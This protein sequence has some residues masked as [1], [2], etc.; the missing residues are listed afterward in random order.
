MA[1]V[2][3]LVR[4][5]KCPVGGKLRISQGNVVRDKVFDC[6]VQILR[7]VLLLK[8]YQYNASLCEMAASAESFEVITDPIP[9]PSARGARWANT[10]MD[11]IS[12]PSLLPGWPP[13]E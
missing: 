13:V 10:A 2:A 4:A 8:M 12:P 3:K 5:S 9:W 6:A 11:T 1:A 7:G